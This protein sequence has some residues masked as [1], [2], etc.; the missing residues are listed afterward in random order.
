MNIGTKCEW[1]GNRTINV[2]GED[3]LFVYFFILL[4]VCFY[5]SLLFSSGPSQK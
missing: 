4:S 3:L 1:N 5:F 2:M